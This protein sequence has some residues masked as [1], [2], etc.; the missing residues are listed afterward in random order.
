MTRRRRR[1]GFAATG[2]SLELRSIASTA[3]PAGRRLSASAPTPLEGP[4]RRS[5]R[6][7]GYRSPSTPAQSR[8]SELAAGAAM[9][10]KHSITARTDAASSVVIVGLA[11]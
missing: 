11:W 5:Y 10:Q 1:T 9:M 4:D 6:R 2:R 8:S 3:R 7:Y